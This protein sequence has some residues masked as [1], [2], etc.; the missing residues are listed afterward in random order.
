[1]GGS[2]SSTSVQDTSN[3]LNNYS[4]NFSANCGS[5]S[6]GTNS[7]VIT[8]TG[9]VIQNLVQNSSSS[10]SQN[11]RVYN[12]QTAASA[13]TL[14]MSA[15]AVSTTI[16]QQLT[17]FLDDSKSSA[18]TSISSTLANTINQNTVFNCAISS[19]STN[20]VVVDGSGN[21]LNNV[22]QNSTSSAISNC[23]MQGGQSSSIV[24]NVAQAG[25]SSASDTVQSVLQPFV[26]MLQSLMADMIVAAIAFIIFIV[27]IAIVYKMLNP[28]TKNTMVIQPLAQ[29]SVKTT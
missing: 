26:T 6:D 24:A 10:S 9:N 11:C 7:V 15:A 16:A 20:L 18:S 19:N 8:G 5:N 28:N 23:V 12:P 3:V 4:Q 25:S 17:G 22:T 1:M 27:L 13:A 2:S 21:D 14:S 29:S